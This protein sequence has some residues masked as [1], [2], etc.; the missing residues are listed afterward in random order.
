MTID[1]DH[2]HDHP[3]LNKLNIVPQPA[4][5]HHTLVVMFTSVMCALCGM[6]EVVFE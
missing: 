5:S 3:P 2:D 1:H 6:F 4:G